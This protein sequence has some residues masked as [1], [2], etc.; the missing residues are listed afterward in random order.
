MTDSSHAQ[1]LTSHRIT[2]SLLARN[3]VLNFI[4]QIIPIV[5]AVITIP[6]VIHGLGTERFGILS[7]AWVVIGYF[8]MFDLGLG[9][10]TTKFVAEALGKGEKVRIPSIVW[11]SLISQII[12]GILGATILVLVTSFLVERILNI[13]HVFINEAKTILYLLSFSVPIIICSITLRGVLEAAQRFDLVNAVKIPSNCL[14]FLLPAIGVFLGFGLPGIIIL[15]IISRAVTI[16]IYFTLC[17]RIY[18]ELRRSLLLDVK[19]I[20]PLFAFGGWV[21]VCVILGT[22]LMYADRFFIGALRDIADVGYYSVPFEMLSRLGFL[23]LVLGTTIFPAFSAMQ[24]ERDKIN[25]LYVRSVKYL[26]LVMGTVTLVLI[27]FASDIL[28]LWLGGEWA[29]KTTMV[30]QILAVGI[31]FNALT[32]IP[33]NLLDGIGRPDLRAKL[34]F[35]YIFPYA[36]LL[37]FLVDKFGIAG[38]ALAWALRGFLEFTLFFCVTWKVMSLSRSVF[39]SNGMFRGIKVY[40]GLVMI[41]SSLIKISDS[42]LLFEGIITTV[43]LILFFFI[44]WKYVL[45]INDKEPLYSALKKIRGS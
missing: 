5:V 33:G 36:L 9:R 34:F 12:L 41:T 45:D 29:S 30:F 28:H 38:A 16:V 26:L 13:P 42:S 2:G 22:I 37:W 27:I 20:R 19:M 6:Y 11:T 23:P 31:L 14:V 3:V 17:F 25:K 44:T 10:S 21:T 43:C 7:I 24:L 32:H 18:P 15:L 40:G 4:G 39:S 8:G 1:H 35:S